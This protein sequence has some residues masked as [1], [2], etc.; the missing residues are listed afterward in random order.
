MNVPIGQFVSNPSQSI[1]PLQND[2]WKNTG[3]SAA[4]GLS[5]GFDLPFW[6]LR[7]RAPDRKDAPLHTDNLRNYDN[8]I[9]HPTCKSN[10][11]V[12]KKSLRFLIVPRTMDTHI[13]RASIVQFLKV[14]STN[15]YGKKDTVRFAPIERSGT[16][17]KVKNDTPEPE[18]FT[19]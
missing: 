3:F 2:I 6:T 4:R 19:C 12:K 18:P 7:Q 11:P 15:E 8:G 17:S 16:S 10:A 9:R 5:E 14:E 1:S 13:Q